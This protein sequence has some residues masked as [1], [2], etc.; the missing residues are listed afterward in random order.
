M[1]EFGKIDHTNAPEYNQQ[2]STRCKHLRVVVSKR[3]WLASR[4]WFVKHPRRLNGQ[5]SQRKKTWVTFCH[6]STS[7]W[8]Q[9]FRW[10]NQLPWWPCWSVAIFFID[11]QEP[12]HA[13]N[14]SATVTPNGHTWWNWSTRY[15]LFL[16]MKL[17]TSGKRP[18]FLYEASRQGLANCDYDAWRVLAGLGDGKSH[19]ALVCSYLIVRLDEIKWLKAR[20]C[21]ETFP[22]CGPLILLFHFL[23]PSRFVEVLISLHYGYFSWTQGVITNRGQTSCHAACAIWTWWEGSHERQE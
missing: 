7:L 13:V 14:R 6:L 19:C 15:I 10:L 12:C 22:F 5:Y 11:C 18:F 8:R 2:P 20:C 23:V 9:D 4:L 17:Q 16:Q 3:A 21:L 1:S